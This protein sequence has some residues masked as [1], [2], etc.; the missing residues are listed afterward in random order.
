[1]VGPCTFTA[2]VS[3]RVVRRFVRSNN[4]WSFFD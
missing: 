1:M 2:W 3:E 4:A